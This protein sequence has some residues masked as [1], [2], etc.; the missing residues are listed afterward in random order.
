MRRKQF[1]RNMSPFT[2][3]PAP[4][5][6]LPTILWHK[7][8]YPR[9]KETEV[10]ECELT[11]PFIDLPERYSLR[12]FKKGFIIQH[13]LNQLFDILGYL[14]VLAIHN[15]IF[16]IGLKDVEKVYQIEISPQMNYVQL[17][18]KETKV[19]LLIFRRP[20]CLTD[21]PQNQITISRGLYS[22]AG[23]RSIAS[24]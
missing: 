2:L 3:C 23:R 13:D 1:S 16:V 8:R 17:K 4:I 11:F 14:F 19:D 24:H 20:G 15:D 10:L 22:E 7:S 12:D 9:L 18:M 5:K 6:V 21:Q